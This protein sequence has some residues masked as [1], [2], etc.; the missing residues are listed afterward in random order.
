MV[1]KR[2]S[3]FTRRL[4]FR[5]SS[6]MSGK[7]SSPRNNHSKQFREN[8]EAVDWGKSPL[9]GHYKFLPAINEAHIFGGNAEAH[10]IL[11]TLFSACGWKTYLHKKKKNVIRKVHIRH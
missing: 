5:A 1:K 4:V 6:K 7:G 8:Y 9:R 11:K 2:K 10:G 3:D